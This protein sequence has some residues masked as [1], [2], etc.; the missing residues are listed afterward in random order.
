MATPLPEFAVSTRRE[1]PGVEV[2]RRLLGYLLSGKLTPGQRIPSERQL[3]EALSVGRSTVREAL[4]SLSLLGLLEQRV[5]D[6]TYLSRSGSDLLPQVVEWGLLLGENRLE[7]LLEARYNLEVLLA[8]WAAQRR[9]DEQ[10]E[11]LRE[12]TAQM[13]AAGED[14][15]RYV[16]ADIA[17]HLAIGQASG[18]SVLAGVLMNIQ[19]LLQA[20]ASRVIHTAG[21]THTSLAMHE[22]ILAAIE[23]SDPEA[24]RQAMTAHMDR[25]TRRLRS[26]LSNL[27]AQP[28]VNSASTA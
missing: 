2:T 14:F 10:L 23:A 27:D 25:A 4:K 3:S 6:G 1:S 18:N 22:P 20:W 21:E 12:L 15:D 13:R 19:S 16:Q 7:D 8:G 11:R 9:S 26:S 28:E 17:F 24:A 5:G